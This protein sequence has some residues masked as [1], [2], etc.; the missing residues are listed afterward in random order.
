MLKNLRPWDFDT[1]NL[2]NNLLG[3]DKSLFV[4]CGVNYG[5]YSIP[6]SKKKN[7]TVISFDPSKKA[8]SE[9]KK[10]IK[11]NNSKNIKYYNYG[12]SDSISKSLPPD[13]AFIAISI[14]SKSTLEINHGSII[15]GIQLLIMSVIAVPL[16]NASGVF[17]VIS[18]IA[19]IGYTGNSPDSGILSIFGGYLPPLGNFR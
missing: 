4:D 10:N 2:I 6:I 11:L 8:L 16:Y 5:A 18:S 12:I 1:I 15:S 17:D 19:V 9:F 7:T 14:A 3:N 13:A